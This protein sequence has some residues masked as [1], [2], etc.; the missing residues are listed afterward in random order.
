[1]QPQ[2]ECTVSSLTSSGLYC[3]VRLPACLAQVENPS[4]KTG[5][6]PNTHRIRQLPAGEGPRMHMLLQHPFL[7]NTRWER[8]EDL[9]PQI[10]TLLGIKY[11]K[12]NIP[13]LC[14]ASVLSRWSTGVRESTF[15]TTGKCT[16]HPWPLAQVKFLPVENTPKLY[17]ASGLL[18]TAHY[19]QQS[20]QPA[21]AD[22]TPL[23]WYMSKHKTEPQ[24]WWE[25]NQ[26]TNTGHKTQK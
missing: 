14:K 23:L 2:R 1:M 26:P 18:L 25:N 20:L 4:L 15:Y 7:E 19:L 8:A 11:L 10:W 3:Q 24:D 21:K 5:A 9:T 17:S 13:S 6:S 16:P 22:L 12:D